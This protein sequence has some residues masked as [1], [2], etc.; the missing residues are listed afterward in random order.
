MWHI[1]ITTFQMRAIC[2][3]LRAEGMQFYF[4]TQ[5]APF[6][7]QFQSS[8]SFGSN[9]MR[10]KAFVFMRCEPHITPA[11]LLVSTSPHDS[12]SL[13]CSSPRSKQEKVTMKI[14]LTYPRSLDL[15]SSFLP[16]GDEPC[17][18]LPYIFYKLLSDSVSVTGKVG[19]EPGVSVQQ[20]L[21][22]VYSPSWA[23]VNKIPQAGQ[24]KQQISLSLGLPW[25]FRQ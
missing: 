20:F 21:W 19:S 13:Q 22:E 10:I 18:L 2:I 25:W 3:F 7:G 23:A 15:L 24:L 5:N 9:F 11:P 12:S 1:I 14:F 4:V 8:P 17:I 16:N 6:E